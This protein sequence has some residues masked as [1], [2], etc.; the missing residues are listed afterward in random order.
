MDKNYD[1]I[2]FPDKSYDF[3]AP[4][5]QFIENMIKYFPK[6]ERAILKYMDLLDSV[7]KSSRLYF[8]QKALTGILD[9]I[10][11]PLMTRKFFKYSDKNLVL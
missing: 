3:V 4:R 11:Y 7:A 2:I 10:S 9:K 6:E 8:S 1:R 5:A